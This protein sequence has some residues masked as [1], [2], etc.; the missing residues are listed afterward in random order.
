M[1]ETRIVVSIRELESVKLLV[2]QLQQLH[3]NL[4]ERRQP[5]AD[6]LMRIVRRFTDLKIED[7]RV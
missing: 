4:A 1:S 3:R 2:Y 5:E 7:D 6:D